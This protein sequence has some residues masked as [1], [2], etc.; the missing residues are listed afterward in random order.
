MICLGTQGKKD[1]LID[2][3]LSNFFILIW[4]YEKSLLRLLLEVV[5]VPNPWAENTPLEPALDYA[6]EGNSIDSSNLSSF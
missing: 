1:H 6:S 2:R 3:F 4:I 5:G